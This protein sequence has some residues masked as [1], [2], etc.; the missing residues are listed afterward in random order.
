MSGL[1]LVT[2]MWLLLMIALT[3]RSLE[4]PPRWPQPLSVFQVRGTHQTSIV[5]PSI[6]VVLNMYSFI[7]WDVVDEHFSAYRDIC[8]G[9]WSIKVIV[10]TAADWS[11][12]LIKWAHRNLHCYRDTHSLSLEIRRFNQTVG[13]THVYLSIYAFIYSSIH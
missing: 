13:M 9:G 8:E 7:H 2:T 4:E 5:S 10:L 6:L 3:S 12:R 1:A 11:E